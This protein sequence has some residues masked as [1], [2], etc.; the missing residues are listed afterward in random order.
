MEVNRRSSLKGRDKRQSDG[1][2]EVQSW[3]LRACNKGELMGWVN[4]EGI[5]DCSYR[6]GGVKHVGF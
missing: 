2:E 5:R 3:G 4:A 6:D 1:Q